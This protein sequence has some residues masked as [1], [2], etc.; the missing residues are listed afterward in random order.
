MATS[1][2]AGTALGV[3]PAKV[4]LCEVVLSAN[5]TLAGNSAVSLPCKEVYIFA[6]VSN[7]KMAFVSFSSANVSRAMPI[8][9]ITAQAVLSSCHQAS[10]LVF[11]IDDVSNL[12]F[13]GTVDD[14]AVE[15][16]YRQ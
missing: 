2:Y 9:M 16:M 8:P 6:A 4:G 13:F 15:V 1:E 10:P 3:V 5:A 11:T 12:W 7:T 14:E